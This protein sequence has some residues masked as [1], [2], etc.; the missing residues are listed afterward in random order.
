MAPG[1]HAHGARQLPQ[2]L[3]DPGAVAK[4]RSSIYVLSGRSRHRGQAARAA[5]DY[6]GPYLDVPTA[7][8]AMREVP[9]R[10]ERASGTRARRD[11]RLSRQ[12]VCSSAIGERGNT[13]NP[14]P[15][16]TSGRQPVGVATGALR[17]RYSGSDRA[18]EPEREEQPL[19]GGAGSRGEAEGTGRCGEKRQRP[20]RGQPRPPSEIADRSP[21]GSRPSSRNGRARR[22]HAT[23]SIERSRGRRTP[24]RTRFVRDDGGEYRAVRSRCAASTADQPRLDVRQDGGRPSG[25]SDYSTKRRESSWSAPG[26][27][28]AQVEAGTLTPGAALTFGTAKALRMIRRARGNAGAKTMTSSPGFKEERRTRS[29]SA[30]GCG[31]DRPVAPGVDPRA[32]RCAAS[33]H[34][35][36]RRLS[37]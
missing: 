36:N 17:R 25:C 6:D 33:L 27:E 24:T 5:H 30:G 37:M 23:A 22:R 13:R 3:H 9:R 10:T 15:D 19:R 18:D 2:D 12:N 11:S 4:V 7:A 16:A 35:R 29:A 31:S 21:A 1:T 8:S 14:L 34:I 26:L 32:P 28:G 20:R